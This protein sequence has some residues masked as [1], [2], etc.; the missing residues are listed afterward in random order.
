MTA[1]KISGGALLVRPRPLGRG[2][3]VEALCSW[4]FRLGAANGY[5]KLHDFLRQEVG[6]TASLSAGESGWQ[7]SRHLD[8][9]S[10]AALIPSVALADLT[11]EL[12]NLVSEPERFRRWLLCNPKARG[13]QRFCVCPEC[14]QEDLQPY[15]RRHWRL[16]CVT[17]CKIHKRLLVDRCAQCQQPVSLS[18]RR[19]RSLDRC[20]HCGAHYVR[21]LHRAYRVS[22]WRTGDPAFASAA[23]FPITLAYPHLWWDGIRVL[24]QVLSRRRVARKLLNAELPQ[25]ARDA[26]ELSSVSRCEFDSQG[27]H[28]RH[29][30]LAAIDSLLDEWPKRFVSMMS[31]ARITLSDFH[32]CEVSSPY[33]LSVVCRSELDRKAYR[34]SSIEVDAA[35]RVA[36]VGEFKPSKVA[37]KR[38]LGITEAMTLDQ[39]FPHSDRQLTDAQ[40]MAIAELLDADIGCASVRRDHRASLVRDAVVIAAAT[41][42]RISFT[43]ACQLE[44]KD[45][46]ALLE[47]WRAS[48]PIDRSRANL[49]AN[50]L[51]EYIGRTRAR[52]ERFGRPQRALFLSRFG[53]PL[54]GSS[55][56]PRFADLLRRTGVQQWG[57]GARLLQQPIRTQGDAS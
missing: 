57:R 46:I 3:D 7:R 37:V 20:D 33:W 41:Q 55:V 22:P 11:V 12:S 28:Y 38:V 44:L 27:I 5:A 14:M 25:V 23:H 19:S 54:L 21:E 30:M 9:L 53:E 31:N 17:H 51:G 49:Y 8:A 34:V 29:G 35:A 45:G 48:A 36:T 13:D 42:L 18:H 4:A 1:R 47:N 32:A 50:W 39:A 43:K 56:V 15:W 6:W 16:S 24:I 40:L 10:Q 26:L 2:Q 52:F